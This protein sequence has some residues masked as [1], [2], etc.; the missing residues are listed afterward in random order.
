MRWFTSNNLSIFR[1]VPV[2]SSNFPYSVNDKNIFAINPNSNVFSGWQSST[3]DSSE[4]S[5]ELLKEPATPCHD[6][7]Q[8]AAFSP[9]WWTLPKTST[10]LPISKRKHRQ[11]VAH[12]FKDLKCTYTGP[13]SFNYSDGM[14][15]IYLLQDNVSNNLKTNLKKHRCD[16]GGCN[17]KYT[18]SSHLKAHKRIHTGWNWGYF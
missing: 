7:A 1:I 14:T 18:K 8:Y 11:T 3:S 4:N 13:A 6:L 10:N 17:K 9:S 2:E 16:A 5:N 12:D 15:P